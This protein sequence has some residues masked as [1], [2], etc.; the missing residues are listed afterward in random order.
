[1]AVGRKNWLFAGHDE[2]AQGHAVL[3]SLIASA[4]RHDLD[5]QCYLRSVLAHLPAAS[6]SNPPALPPD[7][8]HNYLPEAWKRDLMAEQQTTLNANHAAM[9][10]AA[11]R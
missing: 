8:L 4:Q 10:Q 9:V 7:E 1:M 2:S 11:R 5:V 6:A 3:W